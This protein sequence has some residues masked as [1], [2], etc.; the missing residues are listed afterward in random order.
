MLFFI[1]GLNRSDIQF[2]CNETTDERL[3]LNPELIKLVSCPECANWSLYFYNSTGD[4]VRYVSY[5]FEV[6]DYKTPYMSLDEI[7]RG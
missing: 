1:S 2:F 7:L 4:E 6:H 3:R 5:Q